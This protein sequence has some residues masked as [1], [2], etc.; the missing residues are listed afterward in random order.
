MHSSPWLS[1]FGWRCARAALAVLVAA[2]AALGSCSS[3]SPDVTNPDVPNILILV[4][5][6]GV[7]ADVASLQVRA[8]LNGKSDPVGLN[9]TNNT[10][11]FA[12]TLPNTA[13]SL[14]T[15]RVDGFG[16]DS[17][18]CY[19]ASGS[20]TTQLTA[21]TT[22]QE[23]TLNLTSVG[24]RLCQ[25]VVDI[26]GGGTVTSTPP[27]I[28][29][30]SG[31]NV[32]SFGFAYGTTVTLSG[33]LLAQSY[34]VWSANCV[35]AGAQS[36]TLQDRHPRRRRAARRRPFR[37][38]QLQRRRLLPVQPPALVLLD[39]RPVGQRPERR[40][41]GRRDSVVDHALRRQPVDGDGKPEPQ[42]P[43]PGVGQRP[44]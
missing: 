40:L 39:K 7:L 30:G 44:G 23:L 34:P 24:T 4:N 26:S 20:V 9:I 36:P 3:D 42:Q 10:S 13:P 18:K 17:H 15:L 37:P 41:G 25:L 35:S 43:H 16:L 38:A 29:C 5:V 28:S 12:L 14:G 6:Q 1:R 8:S 19:Q 32:C 11:Q 33:P 27:G 22:Y 31:S 21:G 2:V